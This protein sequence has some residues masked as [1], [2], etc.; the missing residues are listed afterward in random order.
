MDGYIKLD[1]TEVDYFC[2][3]INNISSQVFVI[4]GS[5]IVYIKQLSSL[6]SLDL[7]KEI[8]VQADCILDKD[9]K[10]FKEI[11]TRYG[12]IVHD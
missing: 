1:I 4:D 8:C 9:K 10:L 5:R 6:L 11:I 7:S 12:G 2:S 3:A